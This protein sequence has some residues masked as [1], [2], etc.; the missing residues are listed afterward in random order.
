MTKRTRGV[1]N[2][3]RRRMRLQRIERAV[4]R[5]LIDCYL[6]QTP[7]K[8]KELALFLGVS[9]PYLSRAVGGVSSVALRAM[10]RRKQCS[11]AEE[12]LRLTDLSVREI[13][14]RSAFG[15]VKTFYRA[16]RQWYGMS[17][18]TYRMGLPNAHGRKRG[19]SISSSSSIRKNGK[20]E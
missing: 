11:H 5:Y 13:T 14:L 4:D 18:G 20:P 15:D 8:V 1:G 16:F 7:A 10:M 6:N 17:P 2:A 12:L 19:T 3:I 9:R